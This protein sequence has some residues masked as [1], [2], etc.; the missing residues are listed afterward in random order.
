MRGLKENKVM[1][2]LFNENG[3]MMMMM[4]SDHIFHVLVDMHGYGKLLLKIKTVQ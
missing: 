1:G 3:M 4:M 2:I